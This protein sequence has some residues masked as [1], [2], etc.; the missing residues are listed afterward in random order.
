MN[1]AKSCPRDNAAEGQ[2]QRTL[3]LFGLSPVHAWTSGRRLSGVFVHCDPDR[4]LLPV[5]SE[6]AVTTDELADQEIASAAK[7]RT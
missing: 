6:S 5:M 1:T 2:P 3:L 4:L 7:S